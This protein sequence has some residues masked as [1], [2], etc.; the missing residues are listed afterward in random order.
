MTT[1]RRA[2]FIAGKRTGR[3]SLW[4]TALA[5]CLALSC[6]RSPSTDEAS[7]DLPPVV[8][9]TPPRVPIAPRIADLAV[10]DLTPTPFRL[11]RLSGE[12]DSLITTLTFSTF[13]RSTDPSACRAEFAITYLLTQ[14]RRPTTNADAGLAIATFEGDLVCPTAT[15][16]EGFRTRLELERPFGGLTGLTGETRLEEVL[17]EVLRDGIDIL[18]G[19]L[20]A[21]GAPDSDILENLTH[22]DH[23]GLLGESASEAG[24][25]R[26][27]AAVPNLIRLTA[28]DNR[29]VSMRAGAALGLLRVARPDIIEALVRM[30]EGSDKEKHLVAIHALADLGTPEARRYLESIAMSH[31][32]PV[33]RQL[34]RER[35]NDSPPE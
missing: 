25:R 33:I 13:E 2:T 27:V 4:S 19:Q 17:R 7:G 20:A 16:R 6:T 5:S 10:A 21:R 15:S 31:P 3:R 8:E 14:N 12:L 9:V 23:P 35:L 22:S 32:S 29:R 18:Y 30:T 24:E 34:A 1:T 26:L 28:H 11:S